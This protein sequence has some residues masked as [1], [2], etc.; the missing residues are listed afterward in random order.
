MAITGVGQADMRYRTGRTPGTALHNETCHSFID[1]KE[2][3]VRGGRGRGVDTV[4]C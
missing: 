1:L 2:F 3:G 4:L